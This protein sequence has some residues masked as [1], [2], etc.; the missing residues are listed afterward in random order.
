MNND[1]ANHKKAVIRQL[2]R[3]T[4]SPDPFGKKR[5]Y[6]HHAAWAKKMNGLWVV[7]VC[8]PREKDYRFG[9]GETIREAVKY[10]QEA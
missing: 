3:M 7:K 1:L 8:M 4:N 6:R 2:V 10:A 9:Y 5:E